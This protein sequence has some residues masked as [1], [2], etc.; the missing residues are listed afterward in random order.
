[1]RRKVVKKAARGGHLMAAETDRILRAYHFT[2][3]PST[4]QK[5]FPRRDRALPV[6]PARQEAASE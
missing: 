6:P 2:P 5:R 4:A 3:A 1:M